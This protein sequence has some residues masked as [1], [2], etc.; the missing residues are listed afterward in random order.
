MSPPHIP[1]VAFVR[2]LGVGGEGEVWEAV[3]LRDDGIRVAVKI[4]HTEQG[5]HLLEQWKMVRA[6]R[7]P[8]I[9]RTLH[10]GEIQEEGADRRAYLVMELVVG[11]TLAELLS[12]FADRGARLPL[13]SVI[14]IGE[15]IA[16]GLQAVHLNIDPQ[17]NQPTGIIHRDVKPANVMLGDDGV[18]RLLDFGIAVS[19]D[20]LA[21]EGEMVRG[22]RAYMAPEQHEGATL[23]V[24]ADLFAVGAM[25]YELATGEGLFADTS[26]TLRA[27]VTRST[28]AMVRQ[29]WEQKSSGQA[30]ALVRGRKDQLG[31]LAEVI[32]QC[33]HPDPASRP[34]SALALMES[35][36]S[37]R[38][39]LGED[40]RLAELAQLVRDGTLPT[41]HA[42]ELHWTRTVRDVLLAESAAP[43]PV[44][45][46]EPTPTTDS[47]ETASHPMVVGRPP[48]WM[49]RILAAWALFMAGGLT[50]LLWP[51][52]GPP[53]A[54]AVAEEACDGVD[55]NGD[56]LLAPGEADA[57]G[58]GWVICAQVTAGSGKQAADCDDQDAH[59]FPKAPERCN[60][61][62]DDCSGAPGGDEVDRDGDGALDCA[63]PATCDASAQEL[64]N[65]VDDNCDG[66][67]LPEER[68]DDGDGFV[69]CPASVAKSLKGGLSTGECAE[70]NAQVH[71]GAAE[72]CN[73]L[74]D[75]CDGTVPPEE[76][77]PDGDG[78]RAC[79]PRPDC[80]PFKRDIGPGRSEIPAD[81]VDQDCDG[82]ELCWVD[83]DGDG[84]GT[85]RTRPARLDQKCKGP[86]IT[87]RRGDCD[88]GNVAVYRDA[89]E[90]CN[91]SVDENCNGMQF[92]GCK[93]AVAAAFV[94]TKVSSSTLKT[95]LSLV[96]A[97]HVCDHWRVRWSS[98]PG[99]NPQEQTERGAGIKALRLAIGSKAC[100]EIAVGCCT[101]EG[102]CYETGK[103]RFGE[104]S[105]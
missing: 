105:N 100:V 69:Q 68:D 41:L 25:L 83:D 24:A 27:G 51:A 43:V 85:D 58:D 17:T 81:H 66:L 32:E 55:G 38:G 37:A 72:V 21:E 2:Q 45:G 10:V 67:L 60:G 7:N 8:H 91:T 9:V 61:K 74:D 82:M 49:L 18:V 86:G 40:P 84:R 50:A 103:P 97:G 76:G 34:P 65:G 71:P 3:Q 56:G 19:R 13:P 36:A 87:A 20:A 48:Q 80:A 4:A 23:T 70:G 104:C 90:D 64:C 30:I 89:K 93:P 94:D 5:P 78:A 26:G 79:D 73:G 6:L 59:A 14:A 31:P 62:D 92:D 16:S 15:A 54:P 96:D 47:N 29:I 39:S 46:R 33:I 53:P 98:P 1:G 88:D 77:D 99:M 75:D 35:L 63:A 95:T 57:D 12:W 44:P 22:S 11:H 28:V 102:E 42:D 101:A 52:T